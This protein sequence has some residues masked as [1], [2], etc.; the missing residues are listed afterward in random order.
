MKAKPSK[1]VSN[2]PAPIKPI[3]GGS[4]ATNVDLQNADMAQYKALRAKQGARWAR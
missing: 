3:A 1:P 4:S 2:A